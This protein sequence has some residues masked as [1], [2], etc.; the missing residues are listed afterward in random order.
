MKHLSPLVI[1]SLLHGALAGGNDLASGCVST[2]VLPT[3]VTG[4]YGSLSSSTQQPDT[5]T[6]PSPMSYTPE[7]HE[8]EGSNDSGTESLNAKPN[9]PTSSDSGHESGSRP[10]ISGQPGSSTTAHVSGST[11]APQVVSGAS[12]LIAEIRAEMAVISLLA[13]FVPILVGLI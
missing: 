6:P 10:M 2:T 12:G 11:D 7:Y 13:S 4:C 9:Q 1:L 8:P 5:S 3:V